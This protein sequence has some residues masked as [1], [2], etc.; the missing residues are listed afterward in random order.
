[1][2]MRTFPLLLAFLFTTAFADPKDPTS[3]ADLPAA[4]QKTVR[5]HLGSN[6]VS[7]IERRTEDGDNVY[8]VIF[9][10]NDEE[11]EMTVAEDGILLSIEVSLGE[12]P[13]AVQK[14]VQQQ[15]KGA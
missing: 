4:A 3:L 12:T 10:R 13:P 5:Q 2:S 6:T 15:L 11:R 9:T 14:T 8:D 1:M 7:E